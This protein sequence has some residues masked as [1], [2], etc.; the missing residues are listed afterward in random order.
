MPNVQVKNTDIWKVQILWESVK[1]NRKG[2][3]AH[4]TAAN[5]KREGNKKVPITHRDEMLNFQVKTDI[6]SLGQ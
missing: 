1:A 3:N 6:A 4:K 5:L 2:E